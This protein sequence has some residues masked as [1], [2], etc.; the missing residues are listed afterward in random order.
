MKSSKI[1]S[2]DKVEIKLELCRFNETNEILY[3]DLK[4]K[5]YPE[6]ETFFPTQ[7]ALISG[8]VGRSSLLGV[9]AEDSPWR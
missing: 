3:L 9:A 5:T 8:N 6:W 4:T 7:Q 1:K 2:F